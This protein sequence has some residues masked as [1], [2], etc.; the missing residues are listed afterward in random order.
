MYDKEQKGLVYYCLTQC[1]R[2]TGHKTTKYPSFERERGV[3]KKRREGFK[4]FYYKLPNFF[5]NF[6]IT[7]ILSE[8]ESFLTT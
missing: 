8:F 6:A 3:L 5:L 4:Q 1:I 7:L 2:K